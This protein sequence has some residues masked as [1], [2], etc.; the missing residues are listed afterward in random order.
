[1]ATWLRSSFALLV[2][3]GTPASAGAE[4]GRTG[5]APAL[6]DPTTGMALVFVTG[7]CFLMGASEDDCD[8]TPEERPAHEICVRDFYIGKYEVTRAQWRKVMGSAPSASSTCDRDVCPVDG[9]SFSEVQDYLARL[10]AASRPSGGPRYRLPTEAEWE[11][12]ARSGGRAERFSGGANVDRV[13][14]FAHNSGKVNHPVGAKGP[15]GLGLHDMSG[16]VWEMTS[17]WYGATYYSTSPRDDPAGP[18]SGDDHVIR[19]G[20]RSTGAPHQRTTRRA[21]IADRTQ[22]AGRGGNVGFR[23]V[24]AP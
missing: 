7:G 3:A 13:A 10:S 6:T 4:G 5:V 23:L 12:A 22:G 19:G 24:L 11:Y 18:S 17:D 15:N 20:C 2:L 16:N 14:W 21:P 1:M 9:V 8:A